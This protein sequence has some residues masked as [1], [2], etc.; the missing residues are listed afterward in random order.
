M[1]SSDTTVMGSSEAVPLTCTDSFVFISQ[2]TKTSY[3]TKLSVQVRGTASDDPI[4]G[5]TRRPEDPE[6]RRPGGAPGVVAGKT[7]R[8]SGCASGPPGLR[9]LPATTPGA[10]P[11]LRVSGSYRPLLRVRL[12]ASGS[13]GLTG[14][15]SGC[16]SGSPGLRVFGSP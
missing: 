3:K 11:G 9:V 15:S 1:P 14:H 5:E 4:T 12:W 13:P 16:A 7:R 6:T 2:P 8:P 10:P